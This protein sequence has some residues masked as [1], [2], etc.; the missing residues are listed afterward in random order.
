MERIN[1][2]PFRSEMSDFQFVSFTNK[3]GEEVREQKV[4]INGFEQTQR[5]VATKVP[6]VGTGFSIW[7][8]SMFWS[9]KWP[10]LKGLKC[11]LFLYNKPM[12]N[13]ILWCVNTGTKANPKYHKVV[14][15]SQEKGFFYDPEAF[16]ATKPKGE[17]GDLFL[18]PVFY[19]CNPLAEGNKGIDLSFEKTGIITMKSLWERFEPQDTDTY[20]L[21]M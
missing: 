13:A 14:Y 2:L 7:K 20:E 15:D 9:E 12:K 6:H 17:E 16:W 4:T 11:R 10:S 21:D 18:V 19:G 1:H 3:N 8:F 5:M